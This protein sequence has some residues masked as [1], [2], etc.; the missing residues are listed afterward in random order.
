VPNARDSWPESEQEKMLTTYLNEVKEIV[1]EAKENVTFADMPV[2]EDEDRP[3]DGDSD[4]PSS[5]DDGRPG[6]AD[7]SDSSSGNGSSGKG[8]GPGSQAIDEDLFGYSETRSELTLRE[9]YNLDLW[10]KAFPEERWAYVDKDKE[11]WFFEHGSWALPEVVLTSGYET[12]QL[13]VDRDV[14]SGDGNSRRYAKVPELD[15]NAIN[16]LEAYIAHITPSKDGRYGYFDGKNHYENDVSGGWSYVYNVDPNRVYVNPPDGEDGP[17][18]GE[19]SPLPLTDSDE[20]LYGDS[21]GLRTELEPR[22]LYNLKRWREEYRDYDWAYEDTHGETWIFQD[23]VWVKTTAPLQSYRKVVYRDDQ[24]E[25]L[26]DEKDEEN[27]RLSYYETPMLD[28]YIIGKLRDFPRHTYFDQDGNAYQ[29]DTGQHWYYVYNVDQNREKVN[30]EELRELFF[31]GDFSDDSLEEESE[32]QQQ[33]VIEVPSDEEADRIQ[34]TLELAE[35]KSWIETLDSDIKDGNPMYFLST[36]GSYYFRGANGKW[37]KQTLEPVSGFKIIRNQDVFMFEPLK[38]NGDVVPEENPELM[39]EVFK[40]KLRQY[41]KPIEYGQMNDDLKAYLDATVF[42]NSPQFSAKATF[43][44]G[45][46]SKKKTLQDS[47]C[48]LSS[49]VFQFSFFLLLPDF[50]FL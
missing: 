45:E 43:S 28:E 26:V 31:S 42:D 13:I 20:S 44:V 15:R 5:N 17:P 33:Q 25:F 49:L 27:K 4:M 16:N 41:N 36:D 30:F 9:L 21:E 2:L 7:S 12:V 46:V 10:R 50:P 24:G 14:L 22:E 32:Q 38:V 3:G 19:R 40:R 29:N 48:F 8:D 37:G 39:M 35:A 34:N 23:Y 1:K 47:I 11:K 18:S 6:G